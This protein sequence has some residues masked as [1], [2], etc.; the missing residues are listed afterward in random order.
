MLHLGLE[1]R[2]RQVKEQIILIQ[3]G[4]GIVVLLPGGRGYGASR[5]ERTRPNFGPKREIP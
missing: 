5:E 1:L 4:A 3:H 2:N